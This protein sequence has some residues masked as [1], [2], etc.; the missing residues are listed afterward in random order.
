MEKTRIIGLVALLSLGACGGQSVAG[1]GG[2][3][4]GGQGG[5]GG[6]GT[7]GTT[8]A[9]G[10]G[11]NG[12]SAGSAG[13]AGAGGS[14]GTGSVEGSYD[15]VFKNV[16]ATKRNPLPMTSPPSE[17][18]TVRVDLRAAGA[19]YEAVVT[20]RWG[21]PTAYTVTASDAELKLSGAATVS[22]TSN[23]YITDKWSELRLG[24]DA[25][26]GLSGSV[27]GSGDETS[28]MGD[29]LDMATLTTMGSVAKDGTLPEVRSEVRSPVLPAGQLLP[30]DSI[31]VRAAEGV[32]AKHLQDG[33]SVTRANPDPTAP[34]PVTR[35]VTG[36]TDATSWA[37]AAT[38]AG[39][40]AS[41]DAVGGIGMLVGAAGTA[42]VDRVGQ[43]MSKNF[44]ST[45]TFFDVHLAAS[46]YAL[47]APPT[48]VPAQ[49]GDV[50]VHGMTGADAVCESGMCLV[51]GPFDNN[52]CG[53]PRLG[54][55]G[56]LTAPSIPGGGTATK[57]ALRVRYR[58]LLA[59]PNFIDT[60]GPRPFS[61]DVVALG[62][63]PRTTTFELPIA[64]HDLDAGEFHLVSDFL[65]AV[66]SG[67]DSAAT[68]YGF[69][70]YA[71]TRS[72]ISCGP[73]GGL[74]PP[75]RKTQ[76]VIDK[77]TIEPG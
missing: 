70:I 15:L 25:T 16:V 44:S 3:G 37:G 74:L 7:G 41:W 71:G 19:G 36:P 46:D 48:G 59:G 65:D 53:V 43:T 62:G 31:D 64:L 54:V 2:A 5:T 67:P 13:T 26:G 10:G 75:S 21:T 14:G 52:Y 73:G 27:Q 20:P 63:E 23:G 76:I 66:A 8:T 61:I 4:G 47:G 45:F 33:L 35:W 77:I 58:V 68:E 24:R 49:W 55:A 11:G 69:A 1:S 38:A 32:D 57:V 12:G 56:R 9:A 22:G 50:T 28:T 6:A 51:L 30:W 60:M 34:M 29:V 72:T 40:I 18:A 39:K 42:A 17:G